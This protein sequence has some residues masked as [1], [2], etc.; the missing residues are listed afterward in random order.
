M[1]ENVAPAAPEAALAALERTLLGQ[2]DDNVL[3]KCGH[4][5]GLLRRLAYD[6]ALF[7]RCIALILRIAEATDVNQE[8]NEVRDA[9]VSLFSFFLSGTH[10]TIEQRL[11][12]IGH[13]L[14]SESVKRRSLGLKALAA[15]LE[16]WH[17]ISFYSY[18]F[19]GHSRDFGYRPRTRKD[20]KHWF[21]STLSLAESIACSDQPS[22]MDV[23]LTL[24]SK[25]R[26][27]WTRAG[28]F[29]NLEHVCLA[30]SGKQF[31]REG[32]LAVRQ[33]VSFNSKGFTPEISARLTS[34]EALLR[35]GNIVQKVRSIVFSKNL[36]GANI[37]DFWEGEINDG[38]SGFQRTMSI[39]EDLGRAVATDEPAF[40]ELLAES[41]RAEVSGDGRLW[42]F[43]RGLADARGHPN[44]TWER[45][46]AQLGRTPE[47][48]RNIQVLRGFL[49]GLH[50]RNPELVNGLLDNALQNET[51]AS[52]YP[53]LQG[54]VSVNDQ[55]LGRLMASLELG[56]A[57]VRM[58]GH[59]A[60]CGFG[61]S[62]SA[63]DY[64]ELV[65]TIASKTGGWAVAVGILFARL[66]TKKEGDH[67]YPPEVIDTGCELLR[68]MTFTRDQELDDHNLKVL[69][70][71]C[72]LGEKGSVIVRGI[73]R[74]IRDAESKRDAR[75]YNYPQLIEALFTVHATAA[76]DAL[77]GGS[78]LECEVGVRIIDDVRRHGKNPLDLV[79]G[80]DLIAWC[81]EDPSIRYPAAASI[82]TISENAEETS[83]RQWTKT[84]LRVLEGAPDRISV[85]KR[86]IG[87]FSP[88]WWIG[89]R[90]S[91]IERY[92]KLLD[93]LNAYPDAAV[94]DFIA[95]EKVRIGHEIEAARDYDAIIDR[96]R[97]ER[98]E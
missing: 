82:L 3:Q 2:Q 68:Q 15:A 61:E 14:R 57:P 77:C 22:A 50:Q 70:E 12:L 20:E 87:Q 81:D 74:R 92:T 41:L 46:V 44:A 76:L 86:Y 43:G 89:S 84:A 4:H 71:A 9:F 90:A 95:Q 11:H 17:F 39:A 6:A 26:G 32:W 30:I 59:L 13:L 7:D 29:D 42:Y 34:L 40:A 75:A 65:L 23:R 78:A 51:L 21:K 79:A 53:A 91:I 72:L 56:K 52:L 25:F 60:W 37:G 54:S 45:L 80:D 28:M 66:I 18:D 55:G 24:A 58:Y 98:F 48:R 31:W 49:D 19:G 5:V 88:F 10:A 47:D 69:I 35:P 85:L 97:D 64:Q 27:L 94:I 16:A 67:K 96:A 63:K 62:I 38:E 33:T 36:T 1:F 93:D 73:C 8:S 83:I